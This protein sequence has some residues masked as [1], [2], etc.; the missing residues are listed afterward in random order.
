MTMYMMVEEGTKLHDYYGTAHVQVYKKTC[1]MRH[2][3][4]NFGDH[5]CVR[6]V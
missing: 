2:A 1:V 3:L 4:R 5:L 6:L